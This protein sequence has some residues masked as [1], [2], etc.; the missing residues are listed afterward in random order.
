MNSVD[1]TEPIG[2]AWDGMVERIKENTVLITLKYLFL[3]GWE[4]EQ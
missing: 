3:A 1:Y 2:E 4:I